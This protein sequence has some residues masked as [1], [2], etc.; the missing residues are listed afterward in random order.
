MTRPTVDIV[1]SDN[2]PDTANTVEIELLRSLHEALPQAKNTSFVLSTKSTDGDLVGGLTASTSYGWL[3]IKTLWVSAAYRHKGLGRALMNAAES[4]AQSIGCHSAWL[5]TSTPD[6]V[7]FYR[8][9]GF[10]T[11]GE[12]TNSTGQHPETHRR[13]FMKK[14][15][16][17]TEA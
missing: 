2:D 15:L 8:K 3:L 12:L 1:N 4:K 10:E 11:F 5:D 17:A 9:L 6:A 13:W 7:R 16:S 14:P